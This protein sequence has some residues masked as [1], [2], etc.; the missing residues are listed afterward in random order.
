M[1]GDRISGLPAASSLSGSELTA[2]VQSGVTSKAL[3]S[4]VAAYTRSTLG[5]SAVLNAGVANGVATLN[6]SGYVPSS[7]LNPA[8]VD[9][10]EFKGLWNATTNSPTLTSG[11][12]VQGSLYKVSVSGTTTLDGIASWTAG[13]SLYFDGSTWDRIVG[14]A[15]S[16]AVLSVAGRTGNVVLSSSDISG[17]AASATTDTTDAGNITTGTLDPSV[18][19]LATTLLA[20]A[21]IPDGTTVTVS[22]GVISSTG[23]TYSEGTGITITG[24]TI[25][26]TSGTYDN[27]GAAGTAQA[28]AEA[29]SSNASNIT[30]GTLL[31]SAMPTPTLSQLGGVAASSGTTHQWVRYLNTSGVLVTSQPA[32]TDISG[33]IAAGQQN[34]ATSGALGAVKPDGTTISNSSGAISINLGNAN[35]WSATQT[36]TAPVIGA[37]T[38]SSVTMASMATPSAPASGSVTLYN[39]TSNGL[40]YIAH[41]GGTQI[42]ASTAYVTSAIGTALPVTSELYGGSGSTG[43]AVPVSLDSSLSLTGSGPIILSARPGLEYAL[44]VATTGQLY[45]GTGGAGGA[46]AVTIGSGLALSDFILTAEGGGVTVLSLQYNGVTSIPVPVSSLPTGWS[47][48]GI[49]GMLAQLTTG[50]GLIT[51]LLD[52]NSNPIP[53]GWTF[54]ALIFVEY[55]VIYDIVMLNSFQYLADGWAWYGPSGGAPTMVIG[56]TKSILTSL[57][58]TGVLSVGTWSTYTQSSTPGSPASGTDA[59]YFKSDD[60]LY[61]LTSADIETQVGAPRV[62]PIALTWSSGVTI[63]TLGAIT[64]ANIASVTGNGTISLTAA[65]WTDGSQL[66]IELPIDSTGGYTLAFDGNF[67]FST[68]TP[69]LGPTVAYINTLIRANTLAELRFMYSAARELW[70]CTGAT[71]GY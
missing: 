19:P 68:T 11:S 64:K 47:G 55:G 24:S 42:I 6:S 37:A 35:I 39:N 16:G 21:V 41:T 12:G 50:S 18:L 52:S 8:I 36:F 66:T 13:D 57:A 56:I 26:V 63:T 67:G 28:A 69:A 59:L 70:L 14:S 34:A 40:S 1:A 17:L 25:S 61:S 20:G 4:A 29:F 2:V 30:S 3:L 27:Y 51:G 65:G 45:G 33:T 31:N 44:P 38:A 60:N 54:P 58:V 5:T 48:S 10:L 15:T 22:A 62:T 46:V 49:A 43:V 32:F 53:D 9:G 23:T 71:G 7:Q